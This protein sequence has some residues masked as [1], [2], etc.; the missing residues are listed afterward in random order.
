[1]TEPPD[2]RI[3][4]RRYVMVCVLFWFPLG[5]T[6]APSVLLFTER[7]MSLVAIAGFVAA[8]SLTAAV[9]ELPTGGLSDV[10][11]RRLVL[12]AAGLLNLAAFVFQGL[13]TAPW[14]LTLGMALMGAG[15]ALSSGPAEAWYVDTVQAHSG[16]G[17]ELRTGLARGNSAISA[18]LA[19]GTLL[20]GAVPWALGLGPDAGARLSEATS[21]LVPPL[22]VPLLL[23]AAVE[24][25]FVLYVLAALREPPRPPT[26]L[27]GVLAGVPATV[28][29]GLRLGGR[30]AL[31]RRV[32]LSAGATGSALAAVELLTPG[33]AAALTGASESGAVVFAALACAGF[34][35][36]AVGSHAAPL[37]ARL[38]GGGERAVLVSLG[39]GASGLLLLGATAASTGT[40]TT[41]LAATGYGLVYLG[42]G[43]A[44]PIESDLLHRRVTRSGR[45]TALSV[46]S[47]ALQLVGAVTGLVVGV[48][49]PGP[50]P[51]LLGGAV[52]LAG[53][54]LW[55]RRGGEPP[56]GPSPD[57][58][59]GPR[60]APRDGARAP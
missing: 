9:L 32:L 35:C 14:A 26:T 13:G 45:A 7:G 33:R 19:A 25:A 52:L 37:L 38:A 48:L 55:L 1:M 46:Q 59:A 4:R 44:Q 31:V 17:A 54:L 43:A 2:T 3:A 57:A 8:H 5:L 28:A 53:A 20:G 41:V 11:G 60:E 39:A 16:P 18:A 36:S 15:R 40:A 21:G 49:P 47:L 56:A 58:A 30:D 42:L 24:V 29:D 27:R 50:P 23:A 6:I 51:W 34:V 22:S 12:A 10:L